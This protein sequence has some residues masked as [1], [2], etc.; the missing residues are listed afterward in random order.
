MPNSQSLFDEVGL[1]PERFE[2]FDAPPIRP[3]LP[4]PNQSLNYSHGS[5]PLSMAQ[6]PAQ[7][8]T[9]LGFRG[10]PV[11]PIWPLQSAG[12]SLSNAAGVSTSR[13]Q[14]SAVFDPPIVQID[15]NGNLK[16]VAISPNGTTKSS[17]V[18]ISIDPTASLIVSRGNR[19]SSLTTIMSYVS[20]PSGITFYWDGTNSSQ[21]LEIYRDDGTIEG[22]YSGNFAVTGLTASTTYYFYPYW[23]EIFQQVVFPTGGTGSPAVAFTTPNLLAA[24]QQI[25]REHISL[26]QLGASGITLPSS[27]TGGGGDSGGGGGRHLP[28]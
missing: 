26:F 6:V 25:M 19:I 7:L 1:D 9:S 27:G 5:L 22:P 28:L 4:P 20:T 23:D 24:Q 8:K 13:Q 15:S 16:A 18:P 10:L 12:Q 3:G 17:P 2:T 11:R 14:I 21:E